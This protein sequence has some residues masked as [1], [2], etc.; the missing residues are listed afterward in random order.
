MGNIKS[1][2]IIDISASELTNRRIYNDTGI[3]S[4]REARYM[5]LKVSLDNKTYYCCLSG[6]R[7]ENGE[8]LLTTVGSAA[9]ETLM[10]IPVGKSDQVV[11]KEVKIG[12]TPLDQKVKTVLRKL[13]SGSKVCFFGD[14]EGELDGCFFDVF[15]VSGTVEVIPKQFYL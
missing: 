9:F 6:G 4:G 12:S 11:M 1:K 14:M 7:L 5:V 10:A 2:L 13:P 3:G 15:N 8:V